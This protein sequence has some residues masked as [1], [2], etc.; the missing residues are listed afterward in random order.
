MF[1]KRLLLLLYLFGLVVGV[2]PAFGQESDAPLVVFVLNPDIDSGS[3]FDAGPNGLSA[4]N[5]IF[6]EFGARTQVVN[7]IETVPL[8]AE[9]VV[10]VGPRKPLSIIA[11]TRLWVD[12]ARGKHLLL[13]LDPSGYGATNTETVRSGLVAFMENAYGITVQDALM[14]ENWFT[15]DTIL[16]LSGTFLRTYADV[17]PHPVV[18]PILEYGMPVD[19]WAA[20]PMRIEPIG[21][22]SRAIPLLQTSTAYGETNGDVLLFNGDDPPLERNVEMDITGRINIAG[23]AEN[24]RTGSRVAVLGDSEML[25]NGYGLAT[26]AGSLTPRYLGNRVFAERL[27][28]WLLGLDEDQWPGLPEG[29]TWIALDGDSN[30]WSPSMPIVSDG[31]D[32]AGQN[33]NLRT[34]RALRNDAYGYILAQT[35]GRPA[36]DIQLTITFRDGAQPVIVVANTQQVTI[37]SGDAEPIVIPDAKLVVGSGVEVRLPGR[38]LGDTDQFDSFCAVAGSSEPD[39]LEAVIPILPD[40]TVDPTAL[41]FPEGPLV[42]VTSVRNIVL[43]EE[44][45]SGAPDVTTFAGGSIMRAVGRTEASDWIQVETGNYTGWLFA[46]LVAAN[47][48]VST[49]PITGGPVSE[50]ETE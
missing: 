7:L 29:Y 42:I 37:T 31:L 43:R 45:D 36:Q 12:L 49:L 2:I 40:D 34:V 11:L 44:P 38:V 10:L 9:I 4:L 25:R 21:I 26:E 15:K 28:A 3:P 16:G 5:N 24:T 33:Y 14:A 20:R 46:S 30:D 8:D 1:G 6:K 48:D 35:V 50:P 41:N 19:V 23:L 13:A 47:H 22:Y 27:A 39:C 18:A 32:S 17:V